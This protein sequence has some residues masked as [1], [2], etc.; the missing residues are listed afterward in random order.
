[1]ENEKVDQGGALMPED[2][3]KAVEVICAN[4]G[5]AKNKQTVKNIVHKLPAYEVKRISL[6]SY[7]SATGSRSEVAC[8]IQWK[9][10]NMYHLCHTSTLSETWLE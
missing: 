5:L 10:I 6:Q 2:V 9:Q 4:Y 8:K 1:M 7:V 3:L